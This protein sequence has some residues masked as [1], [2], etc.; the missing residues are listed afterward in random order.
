MGFN[1]VF[2]GLSHAQSLFHV[3]PD[4]TSINFTFRPQS[5]L[6]CSVCI[7][8]QTKIIFLHSIKRLA[9]T[10]KK[11]RVH[12]TVRADPLNEIML[13]SVFECFDMA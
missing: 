12:C 1:S 4:L 7:S 11:S 3:P 10:K 9:F 13:I 6:L 2:K 5:E 8:G